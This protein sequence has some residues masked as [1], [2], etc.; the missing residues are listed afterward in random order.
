MSRFRFVVLG[1]TA[2]AGLLL[3]G[4]ASQYLNANTPLGIYGGYWDRPG[5][6]KLITVGFRGNQ[7]TTQD[8]ADKMVLRRCAELTLAAG[9]HDF[10]VFDSPVDAVAGRP[11]AEINGAVLGGK[12]VPTVFLLVLDK[13]APRSF[14]VGADGVATYQATVQ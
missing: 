1:V 13:P 2:V 11:L 6:G 5:P 8:G 7:Y 14:S 3:S 12:P 10:Q 9:K 4:C